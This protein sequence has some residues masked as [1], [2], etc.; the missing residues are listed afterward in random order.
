MVVEGRRQRGHNEGTSLREDAGYHEK[1]RDEKTQVRNVAEDLRQDRGCPVL[2][3][4]GVTGWEA[5]TTRAID[6][7]SAMMIV[8]CPPMS[9][10]ICEQLARIIG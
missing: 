7:P 4:P 6:G 1:C 8:R 3:H 5:I 10:E 2:F 9:P